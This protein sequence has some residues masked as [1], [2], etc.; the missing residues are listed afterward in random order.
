MLGS[1]LEELRRLLEN[2]LLLRRWV[3]GTTF[4]G[5][6]AFGGERIV[7]A[8]STVSSP[9]D[10]RS[11][12]SGGSACVGGV[13]SGATLSLRD[14]LQRRSPRSPSCSEV[15]DGSGDSRSGVAG[16][17]SSS[18]LESL[19]AQSRPRKARP[20][21]RFRPRRSTPRSPIH[22]VLPFL[23]DSVERSSTSATETG[24]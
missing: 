18:T 17:G 15:E 11:G 16:R 12:G 9:P 5:L 10:A 22:P 7:D 14:R 23:G 20:S 6:A 4:L 19:A 2:I 8:D 3:I 13:S 1:I 21:H 24:S